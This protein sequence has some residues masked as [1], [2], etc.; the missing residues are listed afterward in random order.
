MAFSNYIGT[1]LLMTTLF[2]GWGLGLVGTVRP[3]L[4]PLFV[5]LGWV[6]MLGWSKPWL[7]RFRQGPLEW[8]WRALNEGNMKSHKQ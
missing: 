2:Y 7:S 8:L 3:A 1:S 5:L 4:L 6:V